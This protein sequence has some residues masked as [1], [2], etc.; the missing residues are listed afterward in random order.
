MLGRNRYSRLL[1]FQ[2]EMVATLLGELYNYL[3]ADRPI[4]VH[5]HVAVYLSW[6]PVPCLSIHWQLFDNS[7]Q[8]ARSLAVLPIESPIQLFLLTP[9]TLDLWP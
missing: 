1:S 2:A 8:N 6:A 9:F 5:L 3:A 7:Y 4:D